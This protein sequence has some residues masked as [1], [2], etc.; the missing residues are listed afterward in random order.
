[1]SKS[2]TE[3]KVSPHVYIAG[4]QE[5]GKAIDVA[6]IECAQNQPLKSIYSIFPKEVLI[7][8]LTSTQRLVYAAIKAYYRPNFPTIPSINRIAADIG[9]TRRTVERAIKA[10]E[11]AGLLTR[12][13][14]RRNDGGITSNNYILSDTPCD[15]LSHTPRQN[16]ACPPDT[17]VVSPRHRCRI[18][19]EKFKNNN[20]F[21]K[22][23]TRECAKNATGDMSAQAD[24]PE[25][26][27]LEDF[28][29][30]NKDFE[31]WKALKKLGKQYVQWLVVVRVRQNYY[32]RPASK[33]YNQ[34]ISNE[35]FNQ[36]ISVISGLAGN[37]RGLK[38]GQYLEGEITVGERI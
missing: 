17:D 35:E 14:R 16:V 29:P 13:M 10:L 6:P 5:R 32:L 1:M 11:E 31:M 15:K 21:K 8:G 36:A 38:C 19:E 33:L 9:V 20:I 28:V 34:Y 22:Y 25:Q 24:T 7:C 26:D 30:R 4:G 18:E 37:C 3:V 23:N 27:G 2:R 12:E